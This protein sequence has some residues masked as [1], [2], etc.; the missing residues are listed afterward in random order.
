MI[1]GLLFSWS[2]GLAQVPA[3]TIEVQ[4]QDPRGQVKS[5][6]QASVRGSTGTQ[7]QVR[8]RNDGQPPDLE[9]LDTIHT[10]AFPL[11]DA[12][13]TLT[14]TSG[15]ET[16]EVETS[17][18]QTDANPVV[19]LHLGPNGGL[20]VVQA[21]GSRPSDSQ[22]STSSSSGSGVWVWGGLFLGVGV[23]VGLGLRW[24]GRRPARAVALS[25]LPEHAPIPL[26]SL[27]RGGLDELLTGA[28]AQ[29][30][31]IVVGDP[32]DCAG[33]HAVCADPAISVVELVAAVEREAV[34]LGGPVALLVIDPAR[35]VQDG[36][37]PPLKYLDLLVGGRFPVW[38]VDDP[39]GQSR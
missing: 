21:E 39:Q 7:L 27:A 17:V 31:V 28:L 26:K 10:T 33:A 2:L 13:M 22:S 20:V 14:L 12:S 34:V 38:I 35:I 32:G 19:T 30:R 25:G 18:D 11:A 3:R 29:Y 23:G 1:F 15:G 5:G 8:F 16:W 36:R 4:L 24:I 37:R 6:L 9:A